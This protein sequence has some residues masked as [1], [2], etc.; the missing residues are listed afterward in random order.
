[1]TEQQE[2]LERLK[3]PTKAKLREAFEE[4]KPSV[5]IK[6]TISNVTEK[7]DRVAHYAIKVISPDHTQLIISKEAMRDHIETK[8][9]QAAIVY[10]QPF[11]TKIGECWHFSYMITVL[12]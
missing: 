12:Q 3:D 9:A 7:N 4:F 6:L 5:Y 1:M 11:P 2:F 10:S 8:F